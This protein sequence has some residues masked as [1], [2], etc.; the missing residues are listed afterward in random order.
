MATVG[1]V[2]ERERLLGGAV[3]V[4]LARGLGVSNRE[5]AAATGTSH[6]MLDYYFG[7]RSPLMA[8]VLDRLSEQVLQR[9]AVIA[10]GSGGAMS[11]ASLADVGGEAPEIGTLWLEVVLRARRGE[12]EFIEAADRIGRAWNE[13]LMACLSIDGETADAVIAAVEGAGIVEAARGRAASA[14]AL[15]RLLAALDGGE[16]SR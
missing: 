11:L 3:D 10:S 8:A 7:G 5:L 13:W 4:V 15:R 12:P 6:R 1:F 14:A 16:V 9:L 2:E